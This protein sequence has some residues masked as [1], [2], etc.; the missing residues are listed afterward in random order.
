LLAIV[1]QQSIVY[2]LL[3]CI[4]GTGRIPRVVIGGKRY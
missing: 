4:F 3:L 1:L 2:L